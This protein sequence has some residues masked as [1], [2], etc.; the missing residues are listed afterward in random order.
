MEGVTNS[1]YGY[2]ISGSTPGLEMPVFSR[3][4]LRNPAEDEL[5]GTKTLR[6]IKR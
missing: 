6:F 3:L 4:F 1:D 2:A 5:S